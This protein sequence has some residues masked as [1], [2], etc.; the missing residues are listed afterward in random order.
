MIVNFYHLTASPL[1]RVL[2]T[3]C[4]GLAARGEKVLVVAPEAQLAR[5]DE[6]LWTFAADSFVPH[7]RERAEAQPILLSTAPEPLNGAA[8][9]LLADGE[10]REQALGFARAYYFFDSSGL[11]PARALWRTLKANPE[12]EPHYWKQ[13]GG[14]WVEGP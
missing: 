6:Q 9:I 14:R 2:P 4:Q 3:I 1:E 11:D 7:G 12:V 13:E 8:N 10:W 5:I